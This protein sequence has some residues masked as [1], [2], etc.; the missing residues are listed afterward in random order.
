MDLK[1]A[2]DMGCFDYFE[3]AKVE[4]V[5]VRPD[6]IIFG[7]IEGCDDKFFITQWDDDVSI[8]E[9]LNENEG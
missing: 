6:P 8:E 7:G 2:K 3:V 1:K 9:I 4:T 5:E